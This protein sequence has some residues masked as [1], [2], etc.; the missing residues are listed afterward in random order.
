MSN[1]AQRRA[2]LH[3][4]KREVHREHLVTYM[5]EASDDA[6]LDRHPL[7]RRALKFWRS[8]VPQRKPICLGC[9]ASFANDA[10]AAAFLFAVPALAPT[11]ASVTAICDQCWRALPPDDIERVAARVLRGLI[12]HGRFLDAR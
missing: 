6:S 11:S 10:T 7:L 5:I 4:F 9:R 2:D 12:H 3:Q 1:R 8:N